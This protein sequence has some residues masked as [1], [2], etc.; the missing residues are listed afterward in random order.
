MQGHT[1]PLH[2]VSVNAGTSDPS[3]TRMLADRIASRA[4]KIGGEHGITVEVHTID[5][6][7][8]AKDVTAGV[9]SQFISPELQRALDLLRDADGV[10]ASTPVYKAGPS[11]LF[12]EFFQLLDNDLLIGTP[13]VLAGTGGSSRHALV[14]DDQLRGSFAYLRMLTAP[15]AVYAA[16][17]D[18]QEVGLGSRIDRAATELVLLM[19]SGLRQKLRGDAWGRYQHNFGSAASEARDVGINAQIDLNSDLMRMAAGGRD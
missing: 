6:R 18:W 7:P 3:S 19:Q 13:V 12:S 10:I 14:I 16:P 4:A 2:L 8:L 9:V 5:L 17:E 11:G 1:H 15:T